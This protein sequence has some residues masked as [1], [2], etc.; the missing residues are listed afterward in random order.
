M[1]GFYQGKGGKGAAAAAAPA[2][3]EGLPG[4]PLWDTVDVCSPCGR[5]GG[6]QK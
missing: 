5:S 2:A 6:V 1:G 4:G 3:G